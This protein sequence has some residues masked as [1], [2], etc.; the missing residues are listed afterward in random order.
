MT[1]LAFKVSVLAAALGLGLACSVVLD[2]DLEVECWCGER[3]VG[4]IAGATAI[5]FNGGELPISASETSHEVCLSQ[6]EHLA[7][8]AA[9][10]ADPLYIALRDNLESGAIANCEL[11]GKDAFG[12]L[13]AGTNCATTGVVPVVTN[14]THLGACWEA[15]VVALDEPE[16]CALAQC[17]EFYDCSSEPIV[18]VGDDEG[19][20]DFGWECELPR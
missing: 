5:A 1:R 20:E 4:Q 9:D 19:G 17:E 2:F 15:T 11:A 14:I 10:P 18:G 7:L 8:D 16:P 13:F 6:L 12:E 3:W